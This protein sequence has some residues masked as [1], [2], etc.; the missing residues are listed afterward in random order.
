MPPKV[1]N[2]PA[3]TCARAPVKPKRIPKGKAKATTVQGP[4]MVQDIAL[5]QQQSFELVKIGV[6]AAVRASN[7]FSFLIR[8]ADEYSSG[9]PICFLQVR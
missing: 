8:P 5:S 1:V 3:R 2:R 6:S 7:L 9:Q 4:K